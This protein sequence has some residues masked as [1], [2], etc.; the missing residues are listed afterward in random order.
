[1]QL[2]RITEKS[3]RAETQPLGDFR[4]LREKMAFLTQFQ[5]RFA[6]F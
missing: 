2:K 1:M 6:R 3:L 5:S 4:K